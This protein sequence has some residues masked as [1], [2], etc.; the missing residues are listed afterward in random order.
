MTKCRQL[1]TKTIQQL[2]TYEYM[3]E[4]FLGCFEF[5]RWVV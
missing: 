3:T 5:S 4:D 1:V 2:N